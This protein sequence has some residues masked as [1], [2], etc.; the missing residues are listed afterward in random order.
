MKSAKAP[1]HV[2]QQLMIAFK[3]ETPVEEI[4]KIILKHQLKKLDKLGSSALYLVEVPVTKDLKELQNDLKKED[5]VRYS[6][7]NSIM[8]TMK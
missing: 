2:P 8:K 1:T 4:E 7:L 3:E 6:E 5:K